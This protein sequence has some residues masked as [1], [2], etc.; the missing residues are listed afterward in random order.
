M[1]KKQSDRG[2]AQTI[3]SATRGRAIDD[4]LR[5]MARL[6]APNGCPWDREQDHLSLRWHAVEEVY[7]LKDALEFRRRVTLPW[8]QEKVEMSLCGQEQPVSCLWLDV[9]GEQTLVH[10]FQP[11]TEVM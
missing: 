9:E 10:S 1:K 3:S 8:R 11:S 4:L 7:E 6:R 2:Q 5:T